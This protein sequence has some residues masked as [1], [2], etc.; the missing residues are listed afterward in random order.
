MYCVSNKPSWTQ[1]DSFSA[2]TVGLSRPKNI[3]LDLMIS[4]SREHIIATVYC[5]H[6]YTRI[7]FIKQYDGVRT[8]NQQY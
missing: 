2:D 1:T 5:S 4:R 8:G 3:K 6:D 7:I